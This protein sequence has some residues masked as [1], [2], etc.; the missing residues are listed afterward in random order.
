MHLIATGGTNTVNEESIGTL[1]IVDQTTHPNVPSSTSISMDNDPQDPSLDTQVESIPQ[2]PPTIVKSQHNIEEIHR[3]MMNL[4]PIP[5]AWSHIRHQSGLSLI[6]IYLI[7]MSFVKRHF[8]MVDL[9]VHF[10][11]LISPR[12]KAFDIIYI[13][14]VRNLPIPK[15]SF[16]V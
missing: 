3:D 5:Q 8:V 6:L 10:V 14:P 15:H 11:Q 7:L 2:G 13:I 1:P 12:K 4:I 9:F 16:V